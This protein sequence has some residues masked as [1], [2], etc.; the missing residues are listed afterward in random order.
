MENAIFNDRLRQVLLLALIIFILFILIGNLYFLLPGILG[1]ITLYILGRNMY[2]RLVFMRKW[3]KT[4]TALLF[5]FIFL[6][7]VAIPIYISVELVTPKINSLLKN[8]DKVMAALHTFSDRVFKLTGFKLL[9][10]ENVKNISDKISAMVPKLINSTANILT[11]LIMMFFLLYYMLVNG[12]QVER[13]LQRIIPLE[14]ANVDKLASETKTLIRANALGI[15]I[16]CLIQGIAATLGYWIFG[17]ED[18]ELWGFVTGVFAYFPL[19]G[20]MIV[21]VPLVIYQF[22]MGDNLMATGLT[23]YSI[24]VTGNVDYI[25]RLSLMKKMGN[26]HPLI[27]VLGVI[28]GLGLFGFVGLI[29]GPLLVSYFLVLVKIY[30]NEFTDSKEPDI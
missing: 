29:F 15:P 19:V 26:V 1:G 28:V 24:I 20:T 14:R 2:F 8:Q 17:V 6:I 4:W 18:W 11:N 30:M 27:T 3:S 12:R 23:I 5:I 13:Y 22:S 16:I 21:W 7:I 9:E 25:T 10:E